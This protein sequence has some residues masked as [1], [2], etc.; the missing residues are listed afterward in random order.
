VSHLMILPILVPLIAGS[1][2]LMVYRYKTGRQRSISVTSTVLLTLLGAWAVLTAGSGEYLL[3]Q[4][5]NWPA[6]FGIVLVL[7][8]LSAVMLALSAGLALFCVLYACRGNDRQG[9]HFHALF[10]FQLAGINGAFLTG[11]LFNLFVF[12]EVLLIASYALL[13]HGGGR[14]RSRAG[15]HYVI[16]NLVGSALFLLA[17][18]ILYGLTGTLNMADLAIA[19]ASAP[20]SERALLTGASLLLLVVFGIKAAILPLLFWLPRAYSAASAP[21]AA[22]FAIMTKVGIYAMLRVFLLV[23]GLGEA[24][25]NQTAWGWVWPLALLTLAL[26]GIGVLGSASLRAK[27]A[28]FVIVSVGTLLAA[29]S[30]SGTA[31]L[32]A[33]LFYLIHSTCM[34]AVFFLLADLVGRHREQGYDR[35]TDISPV[36]HRWLLGS[37]F[38]VAGISL[39]GLPPFSGFVG[40]LWILQ[41]TAGQDQGYWLWGILLAVALLTITAVSRAGSS[42]FWKPG[43]LTRPAVPLDR[44]CFAL[45]WM[46]T[47]ISA[48]LSVMAEPVGQ[49]LLLTAEQLHSPEDYLRAVLPEAYAQYQEVPR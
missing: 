9:A 30:F 25:L 48:V 18:G 20:E 2:L 3:Y 10:Q 5:G 46:M 26:G 28:Y 34:T 39:V 42:W 41:S 15:L 38:F 13:L 49:Y 27:T 47:G 1:S 37:L 44:N 7:D 6:P 32:A 14:A 35:F 12:F 29:L 36:G 23:F 8:R 24:P 11:D 40:K 45:V 4:V 21:V 43:E 22:L 31:S 33:A 17:L 16:I 19:V